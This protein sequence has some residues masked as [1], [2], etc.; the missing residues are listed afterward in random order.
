MYKIKL[1]SGEENIIDF[2]E[3]RL[4][5]FGDIKKINDYRESAFG[6]A[7]KDGDF[8]AFNCVQDDK[9]VGGL[10]ISANE[11][12]VNIER[13]FVDKDYRGNG[14]GTYLLE[15]VNKHHD[16]FED[17]FGIELEGITLEPMNDNFDYYY[18]RGF[19]SFG[20]QMYKKF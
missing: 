8:L 6:Q 19:D 13:I 16:F 14:I 10:L 5:A 15:Y 4:K 12:D 3:R 2:E 7:I 17:Y 1:V 9:N 18:D 20:F 11:T